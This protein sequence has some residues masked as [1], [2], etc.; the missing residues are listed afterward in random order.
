MEA[1]GSVHFR[2]LDSRQHSFQINILQHFLLI[3]HSAVMPAVIL[4]GFV[5]LFFSREMYQ[6]GMK[7]LISLHSR[8]SSG[9]DISAESDDYVSLALNSLRHSGIKLNSTSSSGNVSALSKSRRTSFKERYCE[10]RYSSFLQ[11]HYSSGWGHLE[12]TETVMGEKTE[13]EP[14]NL[15][16]NLCTQ[17][18]LLI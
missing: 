17:Q 7:D 4:H 5:A 14:Q 2:K 11:I 8:I 16:M 9:S 13:D 18:I 1:P 6:F 10:C 12:Q 15:L 3:A